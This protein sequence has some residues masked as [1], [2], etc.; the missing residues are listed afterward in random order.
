MRT[1]C[2]FCFKPSFLLFSFRAA[3]AG[4]NAGTDPAVQEESPVKSTLHGFH[5]ALAMALAVTLALSASAQNEKV[6]VSFSGTRGGSHPEAGLSWGPDGSLYGTTEEGGDPTCRIGLTPCG[7]VFKLTPTASGGWAETVI[8]AFTGGWDGSLPKAGVIVDAAGNVYGT[9]SYGGSFTNNC[10]SYACGTVFELS[11][12]SSGGWRETV[13][14]NFSSGVDGGSPEGDLVFDAAGNL[15]GT[16][17]DGGRDSTAA[18]V[19]FR[20]SP[21]ST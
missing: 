5:V 12:T 7:I 13:L 6:L 21:T 14:H 4:A 20:L 8:H 2:A 3:L 10:L 19:V 9:T 18:G 16:A 1:K 15:Y 17:Y 11:P